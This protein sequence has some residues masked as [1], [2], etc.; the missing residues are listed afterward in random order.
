MERLVDVITVSGKPSV[1]E[2]AGNISDFLE[3]RPVVKYD[4]IKDQTTIEVDF[5]RSEESD[6]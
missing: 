3:R 4:P 1:A 6:D 5:Q 2:M